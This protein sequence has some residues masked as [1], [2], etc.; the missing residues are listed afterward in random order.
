MI[1]MHT[2]GYGS[3]RHMLLGSVAA[4]VASRCDVPCLDG[5]TL[6]KR[7]HSDGTARPQTVLCGVSRDW[8]TEAVLK[9]SGELATFSARS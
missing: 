1:M 7:N 6:G 9:H 5:S 4:K 2:H 8:E 3:F